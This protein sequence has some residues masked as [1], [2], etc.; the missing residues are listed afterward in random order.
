MVENS[1]LVSNR[2]MVRDSTEVM[3]SMLAMDSGI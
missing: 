2:V 1:S 3:V